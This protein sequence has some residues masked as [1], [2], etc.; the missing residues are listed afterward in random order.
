MKEKFGEVEKALYQTKNQSGQDPLNFPIRLT[1]KLGYLNSLVGFDD[2]PPTD[3]DIV[4]KNELTAKINT[5]LKTFDELISS[6]IEAFNE[7]FN[8]LKLKY[9]FV[10]E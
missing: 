10:E 6:E 4:V 1:N 8:A 5:Q 3:Q 2:F 9:L 7:E